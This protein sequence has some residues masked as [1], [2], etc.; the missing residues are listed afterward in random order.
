MS[1]FLHL[2]PSNPRVFE[3]LARFH[4]RFI[5]SESPLANVLLQRYANSSTAVINGTGPV[6]AGTPGGSG[7]C[8][9]H[10]PDSTCRL[11]RGNRPPAP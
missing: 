10:F 4:S 11:R 9:H 5:N 7:Q 2:A 6:G 1:A 8:Q 3:I